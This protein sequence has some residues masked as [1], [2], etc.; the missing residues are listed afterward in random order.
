LIY[1]P[2]FQHP[3]IKIDIFRLPNESFLKVILK[4]L[5]DVAQVYK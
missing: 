1:A 2:G 3:Q 5:Y 4:R